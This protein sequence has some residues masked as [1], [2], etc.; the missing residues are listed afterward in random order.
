[1][2]LIAHR[3][4]M[5]GSNIELEN[6]PNQIERALSYNFDVEIDIWYHTYQSSTWNWYLGHDT[7]TTLISQ[8]WLNT[9]PFNKVWFHAKDIATLAQLK[10]EAW[11]IHYFF[12]E[13]DPAVL[14]SS[15]Y[16]WTYPGRM[17]TDQSIMLLPEKEGMS[18]I[19]MF[20]RTVKGICSDY[21]VEI[22]NKLNR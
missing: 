19:E 3:G 12:H 17:L 22:Y 6:T 11:P 2:K 5:Y 13:N 4:L 14:T 9:L 16:I 1:M 15:G 8:E 21:V 18:H 10:R 7:P 20:A